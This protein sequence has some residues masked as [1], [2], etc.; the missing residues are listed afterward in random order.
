MLNMHKQFEHKHTV[1]TGEGTNADE[2]DLVVELGYTPSTIE[3]R[4]GDDKYE[5]KTGMTVKLTTGSTGEVSDD[6]DA[7]TLYTGGESIGYLAGNTPTYQDSGGTEVKD[8]SHID[9]EGTKVIG[10]HLPKL[11]TTNELGAYDNGNKY[12]TKPGFKIK[13]DIFADTDDIFITASR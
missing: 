6:A 5:Y 8:H 12:I 13:S 2:N 3:V 4:I 1:G 9:P 10:T 11:E 7:I